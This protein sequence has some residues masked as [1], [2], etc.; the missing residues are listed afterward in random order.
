MYAT[1]NR[2]LYPTSLADLQPRYLAK[3][4]TCPS[5]GS[6]TYSGAYQVHQRPARFTFCCEGQH[7]RGA[8]SRES[9]NL[10]AYLSDQGLLDHL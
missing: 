8:L 3:L 7:H 6:D 5:A 9:R 2:G 4:P 10:P 1:D